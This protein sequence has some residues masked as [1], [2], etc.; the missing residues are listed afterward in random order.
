MK[1]SEYLALHKCR[2]FLLRRRN[3]KMLG[4]NDIKT[5]KPLP[6][7]QELYNMT[8]KSLHCTDS[9]CC[10]FYHFDGTVPIV[11]EIVYTN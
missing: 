5:T 3:S 8:Y 11:V 6:C 10:L 7:V 9:F 2:A 1:I 4:S